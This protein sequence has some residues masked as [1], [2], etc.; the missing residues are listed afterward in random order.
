[1]PIPE[2]NASINP[3][4][5]QI[6]SRIAIRF[7]LLVFALLIADTLF[8]SYFNARLHPRDTAGDL[9]QTPRLAAAE[10]AQHPGR[11]GPLL[12][13]HP[14]PVRRPAGDRAGAGRR[15]APGARRSPPWSRSP[16]PCSGSSTAAARRTICWRRPT[17]GWARRPKAEAARA[18]VRRKKGVWADKLTPGQQSRGERADKGSG[19]KRRGRLCRAGAGK[20]PRPP[21]GKP[22]R[23][24]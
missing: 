18:F 22:K 1:M 4:A 15:P 24:F 21:K 20:P 23:R 19:G 12:L 10:P 11:P 3:E 7:G 6:L 13:W 17:R 8:V 9:M 16:P 2:P 5:D 14:P